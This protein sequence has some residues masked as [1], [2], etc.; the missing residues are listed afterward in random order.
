MLDQV[1]GTFG[2]EIAP[3]IERLEGRC[4][5]LSLEPPTIERMDRIARSAVRAYDNRFH[6][7]TLDRLSSATRKR[8]ERCRRRVSVEAPY[9]LRPHPEAA[10]LTWLA[11]FVHLR[12]RTLTDDLVDLLIES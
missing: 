2:S 10:R 8:L 12:V 11:A 6:A 1:I 7:G 4:R 9:E 5:A 3:L